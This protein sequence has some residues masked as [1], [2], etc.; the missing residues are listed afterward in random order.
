MADKLKAVGK[1]I[2]ICINPDFKH[3]NLERT[4]RRLSNCVWSSMRH[5]IRETEFLL[6]NMWK[7][8]FYV[9]NLKREWKDWH[10]S[11]IKQFSILG[12]GMI[13][14]WYSFYLNLHTLYSKFYIHISTF[15][16]SHPHFYINISTSIFP[17]LYFYIHIFTF[18]FRIRFFTLFFFNSFYSIF[19]PFQMFFSYNARCADPRSGARVGVAAGHVHQR[20][21]AVDD[22]LNRITSRRHRVFASDVDID[23]RWRRPTRRHQK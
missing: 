11:F 3:P 8:F 18:T 9:L 1:A 4:L 12:R 6:S 15:T 2:R 21:Y 19:S 16:F 20:A 7:P 13:P 5:I 14:G 17:H 23:R 10:W 22:D